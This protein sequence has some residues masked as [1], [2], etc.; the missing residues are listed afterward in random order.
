[1]VGKSYQVVPYNPVWPEQFVAL[2]LPLLEAVGEAALSVEH[3]GSTSVPGLWAKPIIDM[4]IVV[5]GTV[6]VAVAIRRLAKIGYIHRGDLGVDGREAFRSPFDVPRHKVC[7]CPEGN[8][9]L[10]NHLAVRDA[11]RNDTA[12][13]EEYSRL[14]RELA[15]RFPGDIKRYIDGKTNFL[16]AILERDG[17]TRDELENI[18]RRHT[19]C[20]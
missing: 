5:A 12:R 17:F 10:R 1:M 16:L 9:G 3:V 2:S 15:K 6:G 7:V 14:K 4:D 13:A 20:K 18:R 19:V 8:A 11:L